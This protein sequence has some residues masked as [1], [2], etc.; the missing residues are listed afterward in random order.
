MKDLKAIFF[1]RDFVGNSGYY[2]SQELNPQS[3]SRKAEVTFRDGKKLVG[4]RTL[5][6]GKELGSSSPPRIPGRTICASSSPPKTRCKFVGFDVLC[7]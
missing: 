4:T 3:Q 5:T 6:I 7:P 1:A 2:E